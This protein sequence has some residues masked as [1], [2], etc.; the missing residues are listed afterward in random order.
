MGLLLSMFGECLGFHE[1]TDNER[2]PLFEDN[3]DGDRLRLFNEMISKVSK[4][5]HDIERMNI[6]EGNTNDRIKY[7]EK[8]MDALGNALTGSVLQEPDLNSEHDQVVESRLSDVVN[9]V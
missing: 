2:T 9:D 7:L 1:G 5:E 4:M 8:R 3:G 6:Y